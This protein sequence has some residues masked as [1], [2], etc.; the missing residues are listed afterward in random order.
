MPGPLSLPKT[1][2]NLASP[3]SY[4]VLL[5]R[6]TLYRRWASTRLQTL[7]PW[8]NNW[9]NY[10]T[11]AGVKGRGAAEG[12][13]ETAITIEHHKLTQTQYAGG[14]V[15]IHKCFDQSSMTSPPEQVSPPVSS[16]LTAATMNMCR[17]T[18][19]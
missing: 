17:Y 7:Q 18:T 8:I 16:K 5:I 19:P 3:L 9:A 4:R 10:H 2:S 1:P 15:D 13:Y 14:V 6:P 12:W 11:F